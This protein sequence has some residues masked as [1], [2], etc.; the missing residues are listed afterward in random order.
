MKR[1]IA[2]VGVGEAAIPIAKK[3][4]EMRIKTIGFGEKDSLAQDLVDVFI[5]KS[6]FDIDGMEE[7]CKKES[8]NAVIASSEITTESAA[9]LAHK[10]QVPGNECQNGFFGRN[11][12]LMREKIRNVQSIK[13]PRYY[14]YNGQRITKFPVMVKAIDSCGKKGIS[15]V[16]KE[17]ELHEAIQLAKKASSKGQVL[18]EEYIE[19]G[20]EYSVECLADKKEKYIIQITEK[21]TSGPPHF[22]EISHHQPANITIKQKHMIQI[23]AKDILTALGIVCGMAHLEIKIVNNDIYFIEVGARAGGDHIA[24]KLIGLSTD[25]DYYRGAIECSFGVLKDPKVR[26]TACSGIYFH[27]LQNRIYD[28]LFKESKSAQWC[29]ENTITSN[30]YIDANG[31]CEAANS[32]YMIYCANHRIDL[33]DIVNKPEVINN[34]KDAFDLIWNHNKEIGRELSDEELKTGIDKFI[35]NGNVI[36]VLDEN[37]IIAF[38]MLYCNNYETLEAYICNVYVLEKYRGIG[39]SKQILESAIKICANNKF[40]K[41][42]L[43]V[44]YN[45]TVAISLYKKYGFRANGIIKYDNKEKQ[46]EMVKNID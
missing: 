2:I 43:H 1:T 6:I 30:E 45:N 27:C 25:Y 39:L 12:F 4:K 22:T 20:Q 33:N 16:N 37:H 18:I 8:V 36:A 29:V 42:K 9:L 35:K 11:K 28:K 21:F 15:L 41:I 38:L 23:A 13:Q 5:E 34:R 24:D 26:N 32:G 31:N 14:L 3:A 17:E 19:G 7:C 10:L 40:K 46:I 44:A